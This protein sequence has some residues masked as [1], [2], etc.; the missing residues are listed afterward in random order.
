MNVIRELISK[1]D[2]I[3]LAERAGAQFD[4]RSGKSPRSHCPLHGGDNKTAFSI[5]E[6]M[7][8]GEMKQ[9]WKCHTHCDAG[10]DTLDF[11]MRWRGIADVKE[12][13]EELARDFNIS[14]QWNTDP[15]KAEE[16][17]LRRARMDVLDVAQKYF[18]ARLWA[19]EGA[20]ALAYLKRRGFTDDTIKKAGF[21]FT[22]SDRGLLK[23]LL[24]GN[25]DTA[26][27]RQIGLVSY[28]DGIDF[29]A[30]HG[31]DKAA[32]NGYLIYPHRR[33]QRTVYLSSRAVEVPGV[34]RPDP[35]DKSRN[36]PG[37]KQIYRADVP[38]STDQVVMVEGQLDAESLRQMGISAWAMCGLSELPP[39]DLEA[40]KKRKAAYLA[41]DND[42]AGQEKITRLGGRVVD[43]CNKLGPLLMMLPALPVKDY[44]DWLTAELEPARSEIIRR[45]MCQA[46]TWLEFRME[47]AAKCPTMEREERMVQIGHLLAAVPANSRSFYHQR[48]QSI[49][50][51]GKGDIRQLI[52]NSLGKRNGTII[53]EVRDDQLTFLDEPMGNF[54]C[55]ITYELIVDNGQ[56]QP[57][58]KLQLIGG[59]D[60]GT[61]LKQI[62]IEAAEFAAMQWIMKRWGVGP[63]LYVGR[64]DYHRLARAIQEISKDELVREREYTHTG[65]TNI[66][67]EWSYLVAN[68]RISASGLD[69]STRVN[70]TDH[71]LTRYELPEPPKDPT[72][73]FRAVKASLDSLKIGKRRVTALLWAAMYAA[74]L[75]CINPMYAVLWVYGPTQSGKSTVSMLFLTHFGPRFID[76]KQYHAPAEWLS[77]FPALEETAFML[78]DTALVIDDYAPR[79]TSRNEAQQQAITAQNL[80]RTVGNR[81]SKQRARNYQKSPRPPRGMVISTAENP[82]IGQSTV[83]RV[84]YVPVA[85]GDIIQD[86]GKSNQLLNDAQQQAEEGLYA[87]AM[88]L[89][90]QWLSANWDSVEP[91]L[92]ARCTKAEEELRKAEPSLHP[93]LPGYYG[94]LVGCQELALSAFVDMG[95]ITQTE[96]DSINKENSEAIK[97]VIIQQ[98]ATI[99]AESPVRKVF[100]A[101]E[102]LLNRGTGYLCPRRADR[103]VAPDHCELL[104]WYDT[105]RTDTMWVDALTVL[106]VSKRF[107]AALDENLDIRDDML[108]QQMDAAKVIRR[109]DGHHM[110][111]KVTINGRETRVLEI[112]VAAVEALFDISLLRKPEGQQ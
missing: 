12:A 49:L 21:G 112:D 55:K 27:A 44:N 88:S 8:D 65:W 31:G 6:E 79:F 75:T 11:Y 48:A 99:G 17:R 84:I 95:Y 52:N 24:A 103:F 60:D 71:N 2:L 22:P 98:S 3:Q 110:E 63:T 76:S 54:W 5:Y 42:P 51:M 4:H 109:G 108:K 9:Y 25:Y 68:G 72:T 35:D 23:H 77:S 29:T 50:K 97:Q 93:R 64:K 34:Q 57:D 100:L 78:Q 69:T 1:I 38:G 30:F 47:Q 102:G 105:D 45:N 91:D 107:W 66:D 16:E 73:A 70:L 18:A 56:D 53:S 106:E 46:T 33:G 26:L 61:P 7:V 90:I 19:E 83:G 104:G 96:A 89:Y 87:Q 36:L 58:V 92:K 43:M 111:K 94:V 28:D 82:L 13:A 20:P 74:P 86:G 85:K 67:G 39:D 40:L 32:P 14:F 37:S 59:L 101:L 62:D 80:I 15:E 81:S 41:V 10:G